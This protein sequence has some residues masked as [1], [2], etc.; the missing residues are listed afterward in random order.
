MA[1]ALVLSAV[2][3]E[4]VATLLLTAGLI[5][6]HNKMSQER[7]IDDVVIASF[8]RELIMAYVAL[9]MILVAFVLIVV[10]EVTEYA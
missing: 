5:L 9:M 2:T 10:D 3:L 8:H 7:S 1:N 4:I 6:V